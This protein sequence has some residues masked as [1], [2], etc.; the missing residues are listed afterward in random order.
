[1]LNMAKYIG[2]RICASSAISELFRVKNKF[3]FHNNP[4]II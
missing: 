2:I 1:M 4:P 3:C